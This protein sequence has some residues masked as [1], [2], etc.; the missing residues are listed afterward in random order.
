MQLISTPFLHIAAH[1]P[2]AGLSRAGLIALVTKEFTNIK[3]LSQTGLGKGFNVFKA[4]KWIF[5]VR[6][7]R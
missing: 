1:S 2:N 5:N 7:T 4:S 3:K 6:N